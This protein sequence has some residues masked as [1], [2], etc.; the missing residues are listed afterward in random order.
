MFGSVYSTAK[1]NT[2]GGLLEA[3]T[4]LAQSGNLAK[5]RSNSSPDETRRR[6]CS[7]LGHCAGLLLRS[8]ASASDTSRPFASISAS[9]SSGV[10]VSSWLG[11]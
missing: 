3:F 8:T 2:S 5:A 7:G 6:P 1:P 11:A 4:S 10:R 9:S